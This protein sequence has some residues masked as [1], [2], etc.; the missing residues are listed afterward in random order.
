MI[1][2]ADSSAL[3]ALSVCDSLTLLDQLFTE[4]IVPKAVFLEVVKSDKPEAKVL[5]N[6]LK[7]K[8]RKVRTPDVSDISLILL[9]LHVGC[10]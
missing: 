4:V 10:G 8:V 7:E 2:I 6:Y 5:E 1:L 3:V 9:S